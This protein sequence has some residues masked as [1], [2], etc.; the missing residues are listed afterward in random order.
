MNSEALLNAAEQN[1][2][3]LKSLLAH[4]DADYEMAQDRDQKA[5]MASAMGVA[6]DVDKDA[7]MDDQERAAWLMWQNT[8]AIAAAAEAVGAHDVKTDHVE[9]DDGPLDQVA[10]A[11]GGR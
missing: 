9:S 7:Q 10:D 3:N 8:K 6:T 1:R 4:L 2:S 11:L 5:K